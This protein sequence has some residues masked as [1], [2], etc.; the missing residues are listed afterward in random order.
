MAIK[1]G[2]I[3]K[4][5]V[6]IFDYR[7]NPQIEKDDSVDYFFNPQ[8]RNENPNKSQWTILCSEELDCFRN[9]WKKYWNGIVDGIDDGEIPDNAYGVLI[10]DGK[11]IPIGIRSREN[12]QK[13]GCHELY[14]AHF[15]GNRGANNQSVIW[16]GYPADYLVNS[17]DIPSD[18]YLKEWKAKNLLTNSQM[19]KIRRGLDIKWK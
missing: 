1:V 19:N 14:I 13:Q 6:R 12:T 18:C 15:E 5:M 10:Q 2:D 11:V 9:S 8:H 16:H 7:N 4:V 3:E 17:H